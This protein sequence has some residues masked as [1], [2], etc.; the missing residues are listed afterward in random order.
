MKIR[1]DVARFSNDLVQRLY[2]VLLGELADPGQVER[3]DVVYRFATSGVDH[4]LL[5]QLVQRQVDDLNV[6][7]AQLIKIRGEFGERPERWIDGA[8]DTDL[9]VKPDADAHCTRIRQDPRRHVVAA[10]V[11]FM[12]GVFRCRQ[13]RRSCRPSP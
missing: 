4:D 6:G 11:E 2:D 9:A 10:E 7:S 13:T 3:D 12:Q 8:E 5:M 1:G